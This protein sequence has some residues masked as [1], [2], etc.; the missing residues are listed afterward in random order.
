[1][2]A[3]GGE[4]G[5]PVQAAWAAQTGGWGGEGGHGSAADAKPSL[6]GGCL[7]FEC[8]ICMCQ[9]LQAPSKSTVKAEGFGK[10]SA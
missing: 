2:E 4:R 6:P 1:M 9:L 10:A 7:E 8:R 3:V 5:P